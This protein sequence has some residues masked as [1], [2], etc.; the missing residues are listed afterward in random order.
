MTGKVDRLTS[1][2][3]APT[4][5]GTPATPSAPA[6]AA[7]ATPAN[8]TPTA[9]GTFSAEPPPKPLTPAGTH[10]ATSARPSA[11]WG[12]DGDGDDDDV[13]DAQ[14][15]GASPE[16]IRQMRAE[17]RELQGHIRDRVDHLD[18]KWRYTL[19]TT[20]ASELDK[21]ADDSDKIDPATRDALKS[22][23]QVAHQ[24]EDKLAAL[25]Q[26]AA[27]LG[28]GG[29][30]E[31]RTALAKQIVA[32]RKEVSTTVAAATKVVDDAGLK[33]DRLAHA[34]AKIDPKAA[35]KGGSLLDMVERF[36]KIS[37]AYSFG[38]MAQGQQSDIRKKDLK[39]SDEVAK[40]LRQ[41]VDLGAQRR[42]L[43]ELQG[44]PPGRATAAIKG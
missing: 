10:V 5:A 12:G 35:K 17:K 25:K 32:A 36:F 9:A 11:L 20:K 2:P 23:L 44:I 19:N 18:H 43:A 27:Q 7:T 34:E 29:T 6:T 4:Q 33:V 22:K 8:G 21:Y 38:S 39:R 24:A 14:A 16:Q 30:P 37:F 13:R 41:H 31:E 3:A 1:R 40:E 15:H 26:Q 28:H 42:V